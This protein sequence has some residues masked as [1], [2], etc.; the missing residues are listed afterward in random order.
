M[1]ERH[2]ELLVQVDELSGVES[3]VNEVRQGVQSLARA[4]AALQA[5]IAAPHAA[6]TSYTR[7]LENIQEAMEVLRRV[8]RFLFVSS[9]LRAL[10]NGSTGD[11]A[12]A[13]SALAELRGILDEPG[14]DQL[15]LFNA[16][17][18]WVESAHAQ[19]LK[20]SQQLVRDGAMSGSLGDVATG[21]QVWAALSI[22]P[23]NVE[24]LVDQFKATSLEALSQAVSPE[25]IA[26]AMGGGS[27]SGAGKSVKPVN[28]SAAAQWKAA[29]WSRLEAAL[30]KT[31]S[32]A[33]AVWSLQRVAARRQDADTGKSFLELLP[34]PEEHCL[35]DEFWSSLCKTWATTLR[36]VAPAGSFSEQSLVVEYPHL[37]ALSTDFL[38][39]IASST[40]LEP[41]L[42]GAIPGKLSTRAGR[43]AAWMS[44]ISSLETGYL[45]RALSRL[46]D[47]INAMFPTASSGLGNDGSEGI[48]VPS[49]HDISSLAR[50]L[51]TELDAGRPDGGMFLVKVSRAVSKGVQ[52]FAT[53]AEGSASRTPPAVQWTGPPP[54]AQARNIS[55]S[56]S[57]WQLYGAVDTLI[58]SLPPGEG[59]DAV[60][61]GAQALERVGATVIA[62]LFKAFTSSIES[63]LLRMNTEGVYSPRGDSLPL[64][65]TASAYIAELATRLMHFQ[66]GILA[67]FST[68]AP[69][70]QT[71]VSAL[72]TR[73]LEFFVRHAT[74]CRPITE[75]GSMRLVSD[76][77]QLELAVSL[78]QRVEELGPAY[79][80]LRSLKPLLFLDT[81]S[82]ITSNEVNALGSID[83]A[84]YLLSRAPDDLPSPYMAPGWSVDK[85]SEWMDSASD[86]DIW[87]R[88]KS[89]LD[90]YAAQVKS[91]GQTQYDPVYIAMLEIGRR[92][93]SGK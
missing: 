75:S 39:R 82:I 88:I 1:A 59:A 46:F 17:K 47:P 3:V 69:W 35:F 20:Q 24:D 80:A 73:V 33:I 11:V 90:S 57:L 81:P 85:Y 44:S 87:A 41:E 10:L 61:V 62:P 65:G 83:L 27:G 40:N 15:D 25:A 48:R 22:L 51:G 2:G 21:L 34:P 18:S 91:R 38:H 64:G 77:A 7:Q 36:S 12:K 14:S 32:H 79:R 31:A 72:A 67:R 93:T 53:K 58:N 66:R 78:L 54:P 49:S 30:D 28:P 4:I 68:G 52:L 23:K 92:I 84:H 16:E 6:V 86:L 42:D 76:M 60:R 13:A 26:A 45:A 70:V 9:K 56:N 63:T 55:L 19:L 71:A 50:A 5:D 43:G 29:L 74:L 37:L 8:I 89:G